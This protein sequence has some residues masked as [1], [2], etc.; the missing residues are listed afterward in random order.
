MYSPI[1]SFS[2]DDVRLFLS[3]TGWRRKPEKDCGVWEAWQWGRHTLSVLT[4]EEDEHLNSWLWES[5]LSALNTM[6]SNQAHQV[7]MLINFGMALKAK[8]HQCS[9]HPTTSDCS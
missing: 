8:E 5:L 2:P 1:I 4:N 7:D 6:S 3:M 9:S